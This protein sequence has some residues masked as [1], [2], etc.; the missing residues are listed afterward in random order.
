MAIDRTLKLT[1]ELRRHAATFFEREGNGQSL[2]TITHCSVSSDMKRATVFMTVLPVTKEAAALDFAKRKAGELR[3]YVKKHLRT[4][5]I[6]FFD[7][8]IDYGE[9]NR[10]HVEELLNQK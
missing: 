6:P 10:Q 8:Q 5:V 9:K 1:E 4:R 3:E 2:M 7:I